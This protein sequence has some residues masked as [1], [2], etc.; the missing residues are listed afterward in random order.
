MPLPDFYTLNCQLFKIVNVH[1]TVTNW[2]DIYPGGSAAL[3]PS[4]GCTLTVSHIGVRQRTRQEVNDF[5]TGRSRSFG[6]ASGAAFG[7]TKSTGGWSFDFGFGA[8]GP[9]YSEA[10]TATSS[11]PLCMSEQEKDHWRGIGSLWRPQE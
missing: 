2:G 3:P 5:V 11:C 8:G 9:S 4:C 7:V 1:V 6:F 10:N